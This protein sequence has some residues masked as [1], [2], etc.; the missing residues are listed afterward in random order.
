MPHEQHLPAG[1]TVEETTEADIKAAANI[2]CRHGDD[3]VDQDV[4]DLYLVEGF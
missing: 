3:D 1:F 4:Y 2:E